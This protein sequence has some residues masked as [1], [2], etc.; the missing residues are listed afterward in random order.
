SAFEGNTFNLLWNF[1]TTFGFTT[2][3][4]SDL[5]GDEFSEIMLT[6]I[7][8][9]VLLLD[10]SGSVQLNF[11]IP[12]SVNIITF[13]EITQ[14]GMDE[15][16]FGLDNNHILV[17]NGSNQQQLW[18]TELGEEIITFQFIRTNESIH[19]FYNLPD[20]ITDM[21]DLFGFSLTGADDLANLASFDLGMGLGSTG[22]MG[23]L[24][25]S[26]MNLTGTELPLTGLGLMNMLEMEITLIA[27]LQDMKQI[28]SSQK[29]LTG[30]HEVR[31][32]GN[33]T[34]DY[35]LTPMI[36]EDTTTTYIQYKI[37]NFE[38]QPIT[39]HYLALNLTA[40]G[41]P[42]PVERISIEGWN[43]THFVDLGNN[44]IYNITMAELGLNYSN[45]KLL[46]KP[47]IELEEL[48]KTLL[49]VDWLG[50]E[51]RVKINTSGI[52]PNDLS[53]GTWVDVSIE[54]SGIS[55]PGVTSVISYSKTHP[56][57]IVTAVP[58]PNITKDEGTTNILILIIKS[59][60]FW[61]FLIV[62]IVTLMGFSYM[63]R[64]EE[65]EV[66][67][68][69]SKKIIKWLKRR[70]RSWQTLVKANVMNE[71]QY[72]TLHRVRYRI[73]QENL[74]T[75]QIET[76]ADKVLNWNLV[77]H[78]ISTVFLMRFWR[79]V[80]KKSRLIW[81]INT[82]EHMALDPLKHAWA[83]FKTALGYLNPWDMDRQ[84]RRELQKKAVKKKYWK[85]IAPPRKSIRKR[86]VEIITPPSSA[87]KIKPP[88]KKP[89]K[90]WEG[91]YRTDGGTLLKK[92]SSAKK[93]PPFASRDGRIFYTLSQRKFVGMTLRELSKKLEL[94]EFEILVSL[95]RLFEKG[96]IFILQE[97]N[98]LNDDL[99]DVV[100]SLRKY[101]SELE[102]LIDSAETLETEIEEG[103]SF[104]ETEIKNDNGADR[105]NSKMS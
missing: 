15:F 41:Q 60:V 13:S 100:G 14:E 34:I 98:T 68:I 55:M 92:I 101:D 90:D 53:I 35:Q 86:K 88:V 69:A 32:I 73:K 80:N 79:G 36:T 5:I 49:T 45:G 18:I 77:G 52:N 16:I 19:L 51:L 67:T 87:I 7:D 42:L 76:T 93:L 66:K 23:G 59:P 27:N 20:P 47:Y 30:I 96:L 29:A 9:R 6:S 31:Y 11:T 3:T 89:K 24:D 38:E 103:I 85:K 58:V 91:E 4:S 50:R 64:R 74:T 48:E 97:G 102:K 72:H 75:N 12:R 95:V 46:F 33:E 54:L 21:M 39:I 37:R 105:N 99:W 82:L 83:T 8:N 28:S 65:K 40:N 71:N 78:F 104:L 43:G 2:I 25:L 94:P 70:E 44:D 61:A 1:T 57:F 22:G 56:T 26:S 62:G 10:N 17:L 84:R 81:I 63:Q